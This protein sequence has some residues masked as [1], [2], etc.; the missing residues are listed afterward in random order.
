M[1]VT[2]DTEL[3]RLAVGDDNERM[4][5]AAHPVPREVLPPQ[6]DLQDTDAFTLLPSRAALLGRIAER[7]PSTEEFPAALVLVGLLH[8]AS[9]WL[10]PG[11]QL[12][13]VAA[14]LSANVRGDDW[15]ARSGATEFAILFNSTAQDA[16]T[17]ANRLI[18]V[19]AGAGVPGLT[20]CAGIAALSPDASATEVHRRATLCLTTALSVGGGRVLRYRGARR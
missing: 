8:R 4:P 18:E 15:L 10:M 6:F 12:V 5:I 9:G 20:A 11:S 17:A 2:D 3:N 14:A 7:T 1:G 13:Q 16:E 19:V